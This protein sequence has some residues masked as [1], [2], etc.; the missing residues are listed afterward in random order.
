MGIGGIEFQ[1]GKKE[2]NRRKEKGDGGKTIDE[3]VL[4]NDCLYSGGGNVD[5]FHAMQM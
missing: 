3:G 2:G 4:K 1:R 5:E